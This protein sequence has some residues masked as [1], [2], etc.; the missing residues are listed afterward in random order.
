MPARLV[1]IILAFAFAAGCHTTRVPKGTATVAAVR[2]GSTEAAAYREQVLNAVAAKWQEY[3]EKYRSQLPPGKAT[4]E[5]SLDE[6]GVVRSVQ[7]EKTP[8]H[9]LFRKACEYSIRNSQFDPPP[10]VLL[11]DGLHTDAFAFTLH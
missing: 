11:K 1:S 7:L 5:F 10:A 9:S 2:A 4:A 3:A 8:A 6:F